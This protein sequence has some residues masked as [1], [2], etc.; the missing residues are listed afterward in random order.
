MTDNFIHKWEATKIL[1]ITEPELM[2]IVSMGRLRG[3]DQHK[4]PVKHYGRYLVDQTEDDRLPGAILSTRISYFDRGDI[5]DV[6]IKEGIP[7]HGVAPLNFVSPQGTKTETQTASDTAT[8]PTP[9]IDPEAYIQSMAISYLSD[10]EVIIKV[11]KKEVTASCK[12]IGFK[13]TS[14]PWAMFI[15]ILK[16]PNNEY[17]VGIYD[18]N[19]NP[20]NLKA[21]RRGTKLFPNFSK[22]F[23]PFINDKFLVTLASNFNIFK[24]MKGI[25]RDGT[26]RPKFHVYEYRVHNQQDDIK[27]LSKEDITKKLIALSGRY[28]REKD[29]N[30]KDLL[31]IEIGNYAER[32]KKENWITEQQLR[33][34]LSSSDD[35]PA[36]NDV[37]SLIEE[38]TKQL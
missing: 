15:K 2:T 27:S 25:E 6:A 1:G 10:T 7:L 16:D 9:Q 35:Y 32:A 12:D 34:L 22:K 23:I 11:G 36:D 26:Y 38:E 18:K 17:H 5:I 19:K 20:V 37:M 24:N 13:E 31:L 29:Q 3:F 14:K 8:S 30:G 21:Y 4:Q 28:K 33:N